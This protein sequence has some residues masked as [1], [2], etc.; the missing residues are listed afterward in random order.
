MYLVSVRGCI[1]PFRGLGDRKLEGYF[2]Y[3]FVLQDGL[4][5]GCCFTILF[6]KKNGK[7]G[8][9][10]NHEAFGVSREAWID[11]DMR[12]AWEICLHL[13][14]LSKLVIP[15]YGRMGLAIESYCWGWDTINRSYWHSN[16]PWKAINSVKRDSR[17]GK[18]FSPPPLSKAF[19]LNHYL[20]NWRELV[21]LHFLNKDNV[22]LEYLSFEGETKSLFDDVHSIF[23]WT[24]GG[25]VSGHKGRPVQDLNALKRSGPPF[26]PSIKFRRG[27][28]ESETVVAQLEMPS[29]TS[30][31]L[32]REPVRTPSSVVEAATPLSASPIESPTCPSLSPRD[33]LCTFAEEGGVKDTDEAL[34]VETAALEVPATTVP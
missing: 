16:H 7:K 28:V 8:V 23:G 4:H 32:V 30:F 26:A 18:C 33:F 3:R 29:L 10:H 20:V 11:L 27:R 25:A 13:K 15:H 14:G 1:L 9:L 17:A 2:P 6:E 19:E 22:I 5:Q 12:M 31:H 34:S 24:E 21:K